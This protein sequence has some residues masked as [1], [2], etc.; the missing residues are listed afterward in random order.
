ML[1]REEQLLSLK[2]LVLQSVV[3]EIVLLTVRQK[4]IQWNRISNICFGRSSAPVGY[5]F[6][7]RIKPEISLDMSAAKEIDPNGLQGTSFVFLLVC[8]FVWAM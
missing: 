1:V 4:P 8:K 5:T 7:R 6:Q 3:M 2:P